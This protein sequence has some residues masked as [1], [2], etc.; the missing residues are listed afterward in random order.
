MR[1]DVK[2]E[3]EEHL[4]GKPGEMQQVPTGAKKDKVEAHVSTELEYR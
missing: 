3:E 2:E 4:G 1:K